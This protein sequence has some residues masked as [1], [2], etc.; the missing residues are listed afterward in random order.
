M[1]NRNTSPKG[2]NANPQNPSYVQP[3]SEKLEPPQWGG[4]EIWPNEDPQ[5]R[6]AAAKKRREERQ[7]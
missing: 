2:V 6:I 3:A 5:G 7:Q 4:K 1:S